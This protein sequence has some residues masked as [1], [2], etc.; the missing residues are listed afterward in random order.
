VATTAVTYPAGWNRIA[1]P[2][3][4]IITGNQGPLYTLRAGES[5]YEVVPSGT[6]L[7][8]GL[9]YWAYF[10]QSM[11]ET[12]PIATSE[13]ITVPLVP[14]GSVM[15]G[16]PGNIPLTFIG[17]GQV[18]YSFDPRSGYQA[19]TVRGITSAAGVDPSLISHFFGGK[20]GLFTATLDIPS[21][22]PQRMAAALDDG[23]TATL[24]ERFV[25]M[26]LALWE[27]VS[28]AEP[29]RALVRSAVASEEASALLEDFLRAQILHVVVPAIDADRAELR[30]TL[31]ASHLL[32]TALARYVLR[33]GPVADLDREDLVAILAPTIQRYLTPELPGR[34]P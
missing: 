28:T 11:T 34:G 14:N 7:Q 17:A 16:D 4:T 12:L 27:D 23:D 15:I 29:V 9:G 30:A 18:F 6:P 25:R 20:R 31:A 32:G 10:P 2:Q 1:G 33:V 8:A 24:G 13:P 26:Y 21:D 3:G 19:T 22:V 5:A